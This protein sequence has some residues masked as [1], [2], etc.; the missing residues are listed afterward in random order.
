MISVARYRRDAVLREQ[1][2][3]VYRNYLPGIVG[4]F[5]VTL[6]ATIILKLVA[7]VNGENAWLAGSALLCTGA[8]LDWWLNRG[9]VLEPRSQ[10]NKQ[11]LTMFLLG[12]L[13][14]CFPLFFIDGDSTPV[15]TTMT[16]FTTGLVAAALV[17]QS[18]CLPVFLAFA[19]P[20]MV[21]LIVALFS[22]GGVFYPVFGA[23]AILFLLTMI[24]FAFNMERTVNDSIE[25]RFNNLELIDKLQTAIEETREANRAKSIFLASASHDLR[26]PLH[27][28]G[29]FSEGLRASGLSSQQSE[30]LDQISKASGVANDMLNTFLDFSKLDA[31]VVENDPRDFRIGAL[32]VRL[33]QE[34]APSADNKGLLYR[35]RETNAVGFA[36]PSLVELVLRNLISNAIRYTEEGG[37]L[38]GVRPRADGMLSV[39]VW[40][41]GLG[42]PDDQIG[43][44]FKEFRQLGNPERDREKGFGL[45]LAIAKGLSS[46]MSLELS[47]DSKVDRGSV[48][49]LTIPASSAT[50]VEDV[51]GE[52][53]PARFEGQRVLVIDDEAQIRAA[54]QHLLESWGC[55]C[56]TAESE[57]IAG[58][59]V[60]DDVVDLM[61]VDYR[62][63]ENRT[64]RDAINNLRARWNRRIPAIIITGDTAPDRLR[65]ARSAD[66]ELL[67]KPTTASQLQRLMSE[68]L[69]NG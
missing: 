6:M 68:L 53:T 13:W 2:G 31:G 11:V 46:L 34:L 56:V 8:M 33:E 36:D 25:L 3:L 5:L 48:F 26:Q 42:I 23:A 24:W 61:I 1:V 30:I 63:R 60:G 15:M 44:I 21:G 51:P 39:E 19:L 17:M 9:N 12:V 43:E 55:R 14:A 4:Y 59:L 66:A 67:H 29:L 54:M 35:T 65:E 64:G 62:L 41:T 22:L 38:V 49:R 50:I 7:D 27:A 45:G 10:A 40:D 69:P 32:L 57:D 52:E 47:V 18:P 37:V 28:L 20:S 58:R 16:A